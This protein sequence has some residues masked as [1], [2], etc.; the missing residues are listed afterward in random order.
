MIICGLAAEDELAPKAEPEP[1]S[2]VLE[3]LLILERKPVPR[4]EGE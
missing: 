3:F 1:A 4:L 2:L